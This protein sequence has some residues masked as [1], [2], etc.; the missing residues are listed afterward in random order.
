MAR[1]TTSMDWKT[2]KKALPPSVTPKFDAIPVRALGCT[3]ALTG[4]TCREKG[5]SRSGQ[6]IASQWSSVYGGGGIIFR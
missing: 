4:L 5:K 3:T 1:Y 6:G 2:Y